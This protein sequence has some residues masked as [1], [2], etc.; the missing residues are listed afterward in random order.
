VPTLLVQIEAD[1]EACI[2]ETKVL[3][4]VRHRQ[5]CIEDFQQRRWRIACECVVSLLR[6]GHQLVELDCSVAARPVEIS[7]RLAGP[8]GTGTVGTSGRAGYS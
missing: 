8:A 5:N 3:F 7:K 1:M 4:E 2:Q 6:Q